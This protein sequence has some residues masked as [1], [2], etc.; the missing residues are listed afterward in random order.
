MGVKRLRG[1]RVNLTAFEAD[2]LWLIL[3]TCG[4]IAMD[5]FDFVETP[6]PTRFGDNR[7][8]AWECILDKISK[9]T[10]Q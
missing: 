2:W 8:E 9:V 10:P 1:G 6:M 7:G 3:D 5:T 4:E